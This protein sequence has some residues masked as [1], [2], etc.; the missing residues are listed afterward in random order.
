MK[1]KLSHIN[2]IGKA[3][4]VDV[5]DKET[6][7]RSAEAYAEVKVSEEI[8]KAI[9]TNTVKK[10]DVLS[11][12]KFAGIQAAK[13]TSEVIPLCHNIFISKIDVELRLNSKNKTVEIKSFAK[14]TAQTGIEM[15]ALTAVSV[16]ALTV[17]DMCKAIDKSMVIGEVK[18]LSK[19]GGKSGKY[20]L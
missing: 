6:T 17:Y 19:A 12:A 2:G 11:I 8:F 15:E 14:T 9:K 13:K 3:T 1:K 7:T 16:A 4:M 5:S 20:R 10:G 18:L